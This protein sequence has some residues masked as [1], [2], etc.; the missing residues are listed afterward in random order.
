ML[1]EQHASWLALNNVV[2]C[3]NNCVYCFLLQRGCLPEIR[4]SPQKAVENLL[5]SKLYRKDI[6]ICIMPNTDAFATPLNKKQLFLVCQALKRQHVPN[7]ITVITKRKVTQQDCAYIAGFRK[8]GLNI[9]IYVSYSGLEAK[10]E[11]GIRHQNSLE[12]IETMKNLKKHHIPCVHYWRPLLPQ[13]TNIKTL[14]TVLNTVKKYCI[15]SCMTGLKLYPYMNCQTYWPEAQKLFDNGI[16]PECF[17]PKESFDNIIKLA[18]EA[19]YRVFVDNVCILSDMQKIPCKYGIYNSHRCRKYN[20]CSEKQRQ[21]C[22]QFYDFQQPHQ[23]QTGK[24]YLLS[25]ILE[26]AKQ[27]KVSIMKQKVNK[28]SY[29]QSSFTNDEWVEL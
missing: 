23:L 27:Q 8:R 25:D 5:S 1:I 22:G 14:Q 29:W 9:C 28:S 26:I 19:N 7:L 17:V 18:T 15:G 21:R 11:K 2:G 6:P 24:N 13:N 12:A 4:C 3:P 10:F 16:N 20:L